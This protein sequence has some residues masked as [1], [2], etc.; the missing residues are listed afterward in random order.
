MNFIPPQDETRLRA[1]ASGVLPNGKPVVVNADGTVS[2][3]A[4]VTQA[5]GS[6]QVAAST[7]GVR[8]HAAMDTVNNR[9]VLI[10]AGT[11]SYGTAVVGTISGTSISFG[12]PEVFAAV[13]SEQYPAICFDA[14]AEKVVIAIKDA[15]GSGRKSESLTGTVDPSDNSISFG[16]KVQ[17]DGS[18][19]ISHINLVYD[20]NAEKCVIAY[21]TSGNAYARV[22]T[23]SGTDLSYGTRDEIEAFSGIG[24][25]DNSLCYDS[26][27]NKVIIS[28]GVP[29]GSN[30]VAGR[31]RVGTVSGTDI[32]FGDAQDFS[33]SNPTGIV[34]TFDSNS[35]AVV[36]SYQI[37][38]SGSQGPLKVR[39][40]T[41]SG[42]SIS[43]GT[44]V[45]VTSNDTRQS[46]INFDASANKS[47][48][49]YNDG[50]NSEDGYYAEITVSGNSI[51]ASTP[52]VFQATQA[53]RHTNVI[54]DPTSAQS[55]ISYQHTSNSNKPT[56]N[57][58]RF[59]ST[60]ITAEN[61]IGMSSGGQVASGSSATVD[62]I[63]T[64]N[65]DQSSLTAGQSYFVQTDG[66]IGLTADDPSVF[67]GTA[68][69][70]TKLLVKT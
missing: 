43:Y 65:E 69:S 70:A 30:V 51:T 67:A 44:E 46:F 10:Y 42:T 1:A 17:I 28:Y 12:T 57:I 63:G 45:Q 20:V 60:N 27:Q 55:I 14:K 11:S 36:I 38:S 7:A 49:A 18:N 8:P 54:Y 39:A 52:V 3:V 5:L 58:Y 48:V 6:D 13:D 15:S 32:S 37:I 16:T 35:N 47:L 29:S 9:L 61:Y 22:I 34:A 19:N 62:I 31:S 64:V 25:Q 41:V 68:I 56:C 24:S 21:T 26:N 66:T 23:I 50:T 4:A 59:A 40:G 2:V 53:A 33:S